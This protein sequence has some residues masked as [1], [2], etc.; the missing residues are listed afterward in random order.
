MC[1][2][3]SM[4]AANSTV[5]RDGR[6]EMV[7]AAGLVRGDVLVLAEGDAIGADSRLFLATGLRVQEASLTGESEAT[8]KGVATL[9]A[10][11]PIGDRHNM[12]Y[13]GTA[14]VQ[15][16]GRAIVTGTGMDTEMGAIADLLDSTEAEDTPLQ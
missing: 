3:D 11:A 8:D 1:I 4:T 7:N 2:R 6:L 10:R 14:V 15:G 12:V 9:A 5:L 16:V 13:K